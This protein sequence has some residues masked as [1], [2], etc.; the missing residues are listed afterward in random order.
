MKRLYILIITALMVFCIVSVVLGGEDED[1][2][3]AYNLYQ[4]PAYKMAREYFEKFIQTYPESDKADDA[5]LFIGHCTFHLGEY[6]KAIEEYKRLLSDYPA[7]DLQIDA[8]R[9]I[10]D[11]W[12]QQGKSEEAIKAYQEVLQKISEPEALSFILYQIGESLYNLGK[13]DEALVYYDRL[14]KDYPSAKEVEGTLYSKAWSLYKLKR[15]E[16]AS[17]TF[18]SFVDK[19]PKNNFAP[20]AAYMAGECNFLLGKWQDSISGYQRVLN[21]YGD[22]RE[23]AAKSTLKIGQAYV[24]L[25]MLDEARISFDKYMHDYP[26]SKEGL[27]EAQYGIAEVLYTQKKIS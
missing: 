22:S 16:P 10:A 20:E 27:A 12:A 26:E 13:Y 11:S 15:F 3:F 21:S 17:Q 1:Y 18:T 9:G 23:F 14:L 19:F 8:L 5:R 2:T 25:N 6:E 24:E 7:S 4:E